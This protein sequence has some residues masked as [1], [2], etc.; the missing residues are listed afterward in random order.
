MMQRYRNKAAELGVSV[1]WV[2]KW[3]SRFERDGEAGLLPQKLSRRRGP[4]DGVDQ[5]WLDIARAVIDEQTE[6]SKI[7]R[8]L[9][10]QQISARVVREHGEGV[11]RMP[12]R[13]KSYALLNELSRGRN[14]FTGSAK[15]SREIAGRP[16]G[17]YGRLRATRLG[18]YLVLDTTPLDVYAMEPIT[19]RWVGAALT[20][21]LDLYT[22][23]IVGLCLTPV[24]ASV[25]N[26]MAKASRTAW[27]QHR[28]YSQDRKPYN[29]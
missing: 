11:V 24:S 14:T 3:V 23:C 25:T 7:T 15:G 9:A 19:L 27:S 13:T 10:L 22:R 16:E 4:L 20:V 8:D 29:G 12:R 6:G 17:V 28:S 2:R 18:E 1:A 5:R 21:A 26:T